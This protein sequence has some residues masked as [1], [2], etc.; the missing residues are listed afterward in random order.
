MRRAAPAGV[1][2]CSL[3][4]PLTGCGDD[5]PTSNSTGSPQ[6]ATTA[7]PS[8]SCTPKVRPGKIV[9]KVLTP[10]AWGVAVRDDGLT[11]FAEPFSNAVG[12]TSTT[13]RTILGAIPTGDNSNPIGLAFSPDGA[14][15]YVTNLGTNQVGV[16]DV[17]SAQM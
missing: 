8:Q 3:L 11:Y 9:E 14:T 10:P 1:L 13:T 15:A 12:I 17:A 5:T 4:L 2:L 6:Y 7:A 16:I